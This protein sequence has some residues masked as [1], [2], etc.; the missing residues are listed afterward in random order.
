[1]QEGLQ[2]GY[3]IATVARWSTLNR[4]EERA[5]TQKAITMDNMMSLA[6][7][8]EEAESDGGIKRPLSPHLMREHG[9]R[10]VPA[11]MVANDT[12]PTAMAVDARVSSPPAK[13]RD[14]KCTPHA[15]RSPVPVG[16]NSDCSGNLTISAAAV[17][18]IDSSLLTDGRR[19]STVST[20]GSEENFENYEDDEEDIDD[21]DDDDDDDDDVDDDDDGDGDGDDESGTVEGSEEWFKGLVQR[22]REKNPNRGGGKGPAGGKWREEEDA[23]LRCIVRAHGAKNWKKVAEM[24]GTNRTDVQCLHRWN[25]VLKP[26]LH[27][28]PWTQEEDE[29]VKNMVDKNG[30][31]QVKWSVIASVLPGRIGKQCRE[32]WFNHLDPAIK[33]GKWA[34]EEDQVLFESQRYLGNRWCEIVKLLPG[35]TENAVKNRFNSA[36]RKKW[37]KSHP[38]GTCTLGP[39]MVEKLKEVYE[40]AQQETEARQAQQKASRMASA[41]AARA[42]AASTASSSAGASA[43]STNAPSKAGGTGRRRSSCASTKSAAGTSQKSAA[44]RAASKTQSSRKG[45]TSAPGGPIGLSSSGLNSQLVPPR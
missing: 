45:S 20:A 8:M 16:V 35:R 33:K 44:F 40:Q 19:P 31:G 14:G 26:G 34:D 6:M 24:L 43:A 15:M 10:E 38:E 23:T 29:I 22:V 11:A 12:V 4:R 5:S 1:V 21:E 42:S 3:C 36:A 9:A 2:A 37:L 32:R 28:G 18:T 7:S 25:K 30:V 27:K 39:E 41:G 17:A 13:R